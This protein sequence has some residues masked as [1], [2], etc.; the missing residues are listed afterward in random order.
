VTCGGYEFK[1]NL[2]KRFYRH[3]LISKAEK[4]YSSEFDSVLYCAWFCDDADDELSV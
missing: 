4:N 2:A 1:S 3:H